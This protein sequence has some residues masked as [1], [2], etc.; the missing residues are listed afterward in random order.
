[1]LH[2]ANINVPGCRAPSCVSLI[3]TFHREFAVDT[4]ECEHQ[5]PGFKAGLKEKFGGRVANSRSMK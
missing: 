3:L 2:L 4:L 1:M 5:L